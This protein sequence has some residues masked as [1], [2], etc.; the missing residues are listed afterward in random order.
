MFEF[1]AQNLLKKT[2]ELENIF[3]KR[4]ERGPKKEDDVLAFSVSHCL[5]NAAVLASMGRSVVVSPLSF[6]LLESGNLQ[7]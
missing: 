4:C 3:G 7:I 5:V 6:P 2:I 1:L